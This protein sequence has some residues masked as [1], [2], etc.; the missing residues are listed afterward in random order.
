[1]ALFASTLKFFFCAFEE[2]VLPLINCKKNGL[3]ESHSIILSL[4]ENYETAFPGLSIEHLPIAHRI[5]QV[6]R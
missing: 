6:R 3:E 5:A 4:V 2:L 1:M